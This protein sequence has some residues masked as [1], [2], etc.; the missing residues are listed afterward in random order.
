MSTFCIGSI[1]NHKSSTLWLNA[2]CYPPWG[3]SL[4]QGVVMLRWNRE[5]LH[6]FYP[7]TLFL[8]AVKNILWENVDCFPYQGVLLEGDQCLNSSTRAEGRE[9][10]AML[11]PISR[12]GG[13]SSVQTS[14]CVGDSNDFSLFPSPFL[15]TTCQ[16]NIAMCPRHRFYS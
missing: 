16:L 9:K 8:S 7:S 2:D 1:I 3:R 5:K 13:C 11:F 14:I 4:L 10:A 12:L 6:W 15:S